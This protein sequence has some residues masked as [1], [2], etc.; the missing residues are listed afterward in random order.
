MIRLEPGER[1]RD[2]GSSS[3]YR[4]GQKEQGE[5]R[6]MLEYPLKKQKKHDISEGK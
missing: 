4:P 6:E 3:T 2:G 5:E 1:Q